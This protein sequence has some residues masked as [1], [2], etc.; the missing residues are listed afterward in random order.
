M[1]ES[2]FIEQNKQKWIDFEQ[3]NSKKQKNPKLLSKFFIQI[4]DD[5]SYAR[6]FY[7]NRLIR[8]YLNGAAQYIFYGIYKN[9]KSTFKNF[10]HFW[11]V[12]LPLSVYRARRAFLI[13][14]LV[15]ALSFL[16]G[17]L[18]AAKDP[19]FSNLILGENY[20]QKTLENIKKGDPMAIYKQ[21]AAFSMYLQITYNNLIVSF[22]T[23]VSGIFFALGSIFMMIKNGVMVGVFQ[24]FFIERGLFWESFLT[25]WQHGTL[26][27]S[28]IIIAGAAGLTMGKGIVFP[29]TLS[30]YES[31]K[32]SAKRGLK[33]MAGITP[34]IIFAAF[35]ESFFTRFTDAPVWLRILVIVCSLL[36]VLGY[37]LWYPRKLASNSE[38][39]QSD[40]ETLSSSEITLLKKDA[41]YTPQEL[42]SNTFNFFSRFFPKYSKF[43]LIA[44]LIN[45][46]VICMYF[47]YTSSDE[48]SVYS[49]SFNS[50]LA[51]FNYQNYL[52]FLVLNIVLFSTFL[53]FNFYTVRK[54]MD[55][56][57][58]KSA[59]TFKFL[60]KKEFYNHLF[61]IVLLNISFFI[62][63]YW[64]LAIVLLVLPF[65][66]FFAFTASYENRNILNGMYFSFVLL[67]NSWLKLIGLY[68]KLIV[69]GFV[70]MLLISLPQF[71]SFLNVILWNVNLQE[72]IYLLFYFYVRIFLLT[73]IMMLI[74]G[75]VYTGIS[76]FYFDAKEM[77]TAHFLKERIRNIGTKKRIFGYEIESNS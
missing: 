23:F 37:F 68:L 52:F 10:I 73:F 9:E 13:S 44:S 64:G 58:V 72:N 57:L 43:I 51:L 41:V 47:Y 32:L 55:V 24:Y 76:L 20:I 61:S 70:V 21:E 71:W 26:E 18:S 54:I 11:K 74:V 8:V 48:I 42:V 49:A 14:F 34:I 31:F 46:F 35:I 60:F 28:A 50:P 67:K 22:Y 7:R 56:N 30:R 3:E 39:S 66:I 15:F 77:E 59:P 2:K 36:F 40:H 65:L 17:M 45:S 4:T 12:D 5:L 16:I 27:I 19:D 1:K 63:L 38:I 25:I 6:T 33:I 75:I 29:E 53:L 62:G 69:F